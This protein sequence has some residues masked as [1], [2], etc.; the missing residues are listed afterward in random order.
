MRKDLQLE[1]NDKNG[2]SNAGYQNEELKVVEHG[3]DPDLIRNEESYPMKNLT[4]TNSI[5][6]EYT[7]EKQSLSSD[8]EETKKAIEEQASIHSVEQDTVANGF[9]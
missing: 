5:N 2:I 8:N 9:P 7:P 1:S 4:P 6:K 3:D